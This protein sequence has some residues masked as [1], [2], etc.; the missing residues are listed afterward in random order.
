MMAADSASA[1][2]AWQA[3]A[4]ALRDGRIRTSRRT[5]LRISEVCDLELSPPDALLPPNGFGRDCG[6]ARSR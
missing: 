1:A 6:G 5:T 4:A 2:V 3:T